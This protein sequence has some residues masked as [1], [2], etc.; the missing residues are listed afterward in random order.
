MKLTHAVIPILFGAATCGAA[1][2]DIK[3]GLWETS[4]T[5]QAAGMPNAGTMPIPEEAL[6]RMTPEQRSRVEAMRK[7]RSGGSPMTTKVCITR[8]SLSSGAAFSR[9]QNNCSS[10]IVSATPGHQQVH[11]DCDMEGM[12]STGDLTIDRV[13]AEHTKGQMVMK[14]SPQ[15]RPVETKMSFESKWVSADCGNVKPAVAK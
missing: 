11:V 9:Q 6:A 5:M 13:D 1:D 3:L 7:G 15:G 12:K 14:T 8:E 10:K 4:A 2:L